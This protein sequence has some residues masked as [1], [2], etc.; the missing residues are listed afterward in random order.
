LRALE[1]ELATV[2]GEAAGLREELA[3]THRYSAALEQRLSEATGK[4]E[5]VRRDRNRV[6]AG[7]RSTSRSRELVTQAGPG[8]DYNPSGRWIAV[9][10]LLT[11]FIA[12]ALIIHLL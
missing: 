4:L 2:R 6:A 3:R 12:F 8:D 7:A 5:R 9:T 1:T 11:A 10:A